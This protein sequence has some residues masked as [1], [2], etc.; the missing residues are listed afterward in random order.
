M[1][2]VKLPDHRWYLLSLILKNLSTDKLYNEK[3]QEDKPSKERVCKHKYQAV[4]FV[5]KICKRISIDNKAF[6]DKA[7]Q[8]EKMISVYREEY[9]ALLVKI[10]LPT[11][12]RG[13]SME[14]LI[15]QMPELAQR[16]AESW[17]QEREQKL[18]QDIIKDAG[19]IFLLLPT[20][21]ENAHNP[22][23]K[24]AFEAYLKLT[25]EEAEKIKEKEG[26]KDKKGKKAE[27]EP[28]AD[29][30]EIIEVEFDDSHKQLEF[31]REVYV[32]N[33]FDVLEARDAVLE[34]GEALG[35]T[36]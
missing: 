28:Q 19:L 15:K 33:A 9:Q 18:Y 12:V 7:K 11:N 34:I 1:A 3:E 5:D 25:K 6:E 2:K 24:V 10:G 13:P 20:N 29:I 16:E 21:L 22:K 23:Q 36:S 14:E 30:E 31:L 26:N 17:R 32:R 4:T 35:I 8:A 27:P